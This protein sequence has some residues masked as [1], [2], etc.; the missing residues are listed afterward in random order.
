L[1]TSEKDRVADFA[2]PRASRNSVTAPNTTVLIVSSHT[3]VNVKEA[4]VLNAPLS[5]FSSQAALHLNGRAVPLNRRATSPPTLH[6]P[7]TTNSKPHTSA[8]SSATLQHIANTTSSPPT[9]ATP[10]RTASSLPRH[11][12][13]KPPLPH[14]EPCHQTSTPAIR[15]AASQSLQI[16]PNPHSLTHARAMAPS[17]SISTV[18]EKFPHA[19]VAHEDNGGEV[20]HREH[21]SSEKFD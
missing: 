16:Q 15:I 19:L 3:P 7:T 12:L 21:P 13:H 4:H 6:H 20:S 5:I 9:S 1:L 18:P 11:Q 10:R 2:D 8:T 14:K 17:S